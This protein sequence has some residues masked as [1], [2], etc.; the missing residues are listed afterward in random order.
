M[1]PFARL[2]FAAALLLLLPSCVKW[3]MGGCIREAAETRVGVNT[4][5]RY[6]C[7]PE[8]A[9]AAAPADPRRA[10]LYRTVF[11]APE[12]TYH[13]HSPMV[14]TVPLPAPSAV[15]GITPTGNLRVVV[16]FYRKPDGWQTRVRDRW[17]GNRA[18]LEPLAENPEPR[19]RPP[20]YEEWDSHRLGCAEVRRGRW[21]PLLAAAALPFDYL[22]DP[23]LSVVSTPVIWGYACLRSLFQG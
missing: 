18:E 3:D 7:P 2:L 8:A 9:A 6:A 1:T 16:M 22:I 10:G 12:V 23:A 14:N 15:S 21:Y 19:K 11:L 4:N 13:C 20:L 17:E 5:E